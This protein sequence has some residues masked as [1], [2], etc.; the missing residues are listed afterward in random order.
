[1]DTINLD[2]ERS[3]F[4]MVVDLWSYD[5]LVISLCLDD[6]I[7]DISSTLNRERSRHLGYRPFS[8]IESGNSETADLLISA[9][10]DVNIYEKRLG[11]VL[12]QAAREGNEEMINV[13]LKAGARSDVVA[14]VTS[15]RLEM[16]PPHVALLNGKYRAAKL[17][18][19]WYDEKSAPV[20]VTQ[21]RTGSWAIP[22]DIALEIRKLATKYLDDYILQ[23]LDGHS[24]FDTVAEG[25]DVEMA[26]ARAC[27]DQRGKTSQ[28][29]QRYTHH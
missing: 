26:R 11:S 25:T 23:N 15:D 7:F 17:L 18:S 22:K 1:M 16:A 29:L 12:H 20:D 3:A 8:A 27:F 14:Q 5:Q 9:G 6:P 10:A 19:S 2:W 4:H 21:G 13:L 28:K 24:Y